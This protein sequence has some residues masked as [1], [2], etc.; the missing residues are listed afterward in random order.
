MVIT[1]KFDLTKKEYLSVILKM[2]VKRNWWKFLICWIIAIFISFDEEK[3][4]LILFCS[5]FLYSYPLIMMFEYWRFSN[6]KDNRKL[7]GERYYEISIEQ[8]NAYLANGSNSSIK[9]EQFV[10]TFELKDYYFLYVS[11]SQS[12]Y[13]PKRIFKSTE[14]LD[15][16]KKNIYDKIN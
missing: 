16:F 14:D 11:K 15:W 8:I 3:S 10:K 4:G 5:F 7:F 9:F 6:S 2:L 1:E 13:F 12:L